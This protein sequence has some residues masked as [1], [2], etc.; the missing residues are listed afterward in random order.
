MKLI[1]AGTPKVAALVLQELAKEHQISLVITRPD[2]LVG[3]RRDVTPSEVA[4][5]AEQLGIPVLKANRLGQ[6]EVEDIR[7]A[8]A[9]RAIV[10]A[11]GS[12]IPKEAL[13]LFPWWNLHFSLLP[14]W[15]GASPLQYSLIKNFGQG[16]SLFELEAALDTGPLIDSVALQHPD[17]KPAGEILADLAGLGAE[18][19]LRNLAI[20]AL[21]K[22]QE[23]E[24]TFAPKISR[25][26]ARVNFSETATSIQRKIYAFNPEPVAWCKAEGKELRIF[27]ARSFG[28]LHAKSKGVD[29]LE[30]GELKVS[31]G[32]VV[33]GCGQGSKLELIEVQSAGGRRMNAIDWH[34]G[35]GGSKLE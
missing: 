5:L 23:G 1:F 19:I 25:A 15:R 31:Q 8:G 26:D 9:T 32:R 16:I 21:P 34:R 13:E 24:A 22:R 18:M 2:S 7:K 3:R 29:E 28:T 14:A 30:P 6:S 12:I 20:P 33:V 4:K 27:S 17:D 10:V 11:Y 35:F